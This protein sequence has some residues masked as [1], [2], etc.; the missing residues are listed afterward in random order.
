MLPYYLMHSILTILPRWMFVIVLTPSLATTKLYISVYLSFSMGSIYISWCACIGM[1][2]HILSTWLLIYKCLLLHRDDWMSN[3]MIFFPS[4]FLIIS[5]FWF[6]YLS[7]MYLNIVSFVSYFVGLTRNCY[8][9]GISFYMILLHSISDYM[10]GEIR[11]TPSFGSM[12]RR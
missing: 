1:D 10:Y 6:L 11:K 7:I 2:D 8:R 4:W 3:I 9:H 12:L 5:N